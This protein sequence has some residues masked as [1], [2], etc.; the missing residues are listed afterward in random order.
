MNSISRVS[1]NFT[2]LIT[3]YRVIL[4]TIDRRYSKQNMA[5]V[6]VFFRF[7]IFSSQVS[8]VFCIK[9]NHYLR[10]VSL[11]FTLLVA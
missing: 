11:Q 9:S 6:I 1:D 4:M 2:I 10:S 8:S 5:A 3:H 7:L